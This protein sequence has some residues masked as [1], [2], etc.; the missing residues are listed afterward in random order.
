MEISLLEIGIHVVNVV[1][2]FFI[3]RRILYKPVSKFLKK[4][5]DKFQQRQDEI[6]S[7]EKEVEKLK[8]NYSKLLDEAH[9]EAAAIISK[10]NEMAREYSRE[11][12]DNAKENAK[13][14][15]A[16]AKKEIENEKKQA[17]QE[18]K[19]EFAEMAVQIAGKVLEREVSVDDNRKIIDEFF[20]KVG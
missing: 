9:A 14:I 6:E 20:T 8:Q 13:D 2:L 5:E 17:R 15:I 11:I 3:L 4:R 1:I 10:S 16:R 12:I 7:R 18:M 19:V